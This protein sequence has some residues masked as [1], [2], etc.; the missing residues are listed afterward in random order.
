MTVNS[1]DFGGSA[2]V[3]RELFNM[4]H[5]NN[6]EFVTEDELKEQL[7]NVLKLYLKK[8]D[9]DK[10]GQWTTLF[11]SI[12]ARPFFHVSTKNGS[13]YRK[14]WLD[15]HTD[16][17]VW[18]VY[19]IWNISSSSRSSSSM[20]YKSSHFRGFLYLYYLRNWGRQE[21]RRVL[22]WDGRLFDI[23]GQGRVLIRGSARDKKKEVRLTSATGLECSP[24]PC[25]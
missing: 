20:V 8:K 16:V 7:D 1:Q 4:L 17:S 13:A 15:L 6:P 25:R 18:H 10:S 19:K 21:G 5:P 3:A 9:D 23:M 12:S 2:K 22:I 14:H 11:L 24:L